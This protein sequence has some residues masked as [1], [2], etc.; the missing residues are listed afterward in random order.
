MEAAEADARLNIR[1]MSHRY[2]VPYDRLYARSRGRMSK[3]ERPGSNQH[4]TEVQVVAVNDCIARCDTL[5][6]PATIPQLRDAM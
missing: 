1:E 5:G 4:L 3:E 6:M 2:H